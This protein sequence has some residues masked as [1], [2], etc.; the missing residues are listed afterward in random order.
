M[1]PETSF[2]AEDDLLVIKAIKISTMLLYFNLEVLRDQ[3]T[4]KKQKRNKRFLHKSANF[5]VL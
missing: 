4:I 3:T 2:G 5:L 1:E